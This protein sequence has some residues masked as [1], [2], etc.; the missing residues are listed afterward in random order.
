M[1]VNTQTPVCL[2]RELSVDALCE[3][4][5]CDAICVLGSFWPNSRTSFESHVV[6][7]FKESNP[8]E[9]FRPHIAELCDFYARS[10]L[11]ALGDRRFQWVCRVL[12]SA[13]TQPERG[14]PQS[15]LVDVVCRQT[16]AQDITHLFYKSGSRPS[17]RSVARLSGPDALRSRVLYVLQDLFIRPARLGG[18]VLLLDDI[19]NTGASM[20]V[21]A[22]ALREFGRVES[23]LGANLAVTRFSGG[24]DGWG[25]LKLDVSALDGFHGLAEVWVDSREVLHR[26]RDCSAA[27]S[28]VSVEVRFAAERKASMCPVCA[29]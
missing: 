6:K 15:L 23:V 5:P 14:R 25:M 11:N 22:Q 10:L 7:A 27:A 1:A 28:P 8:V 26:V 20:R 12:S 3:R 19:M 9:G 24:K 16:G 17:M 18:S 13:E 4:D 29:K 2:R 21:Y